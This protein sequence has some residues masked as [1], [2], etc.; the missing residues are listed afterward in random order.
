MQVVDKEVSEVTS[1]LPA[2]LPLMAVKVTPF[3]SYGH[4]ISAVSKLLESRG[5]A[6]SV[7]INPEKIYRSSYDQQVRGLLNQAEICICDGVGA[8]LAVRVL[9]G[10]KIGRITGVSLFFKLI[11]AAADRQWKVF[12]LGA[13]PDVNKNAAQKL[14][15]DPA[16]L[17]RLLV[18]RMAISMIR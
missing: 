5:K 6:F 3:D 14:Q 2:S 9:H 10:R 15:E 12:L 16:P 4:V 18:G 11:K 13:A 7:A 1:V 17:F 8:A